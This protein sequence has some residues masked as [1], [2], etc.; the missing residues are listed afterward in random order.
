M[1]S[2]LTWAGAPFVTWSRVGSNG[3]GGGKSDLRMN[4]GQAGRCKQSPPQG[5]GLGDRVAEKRL[6]C[7]GFV[8]E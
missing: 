7:G 5:L 8:K 1:L 4:A 3:R 6:L 2:S